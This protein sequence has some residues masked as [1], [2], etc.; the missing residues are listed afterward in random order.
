MYE[1]RKTKQ[2]RYFDE[3]IRLH[4]EE[5]YGENRMATILPIGLT[6]VWRWI[7]II[8]SQGGDVPCRVEKCE[9]M[10]KGEKTQIASDE[11]RCASEDAGRGSAAELREL[12]LANARLQMELRRERM[13]ADL[14]DEMINVGEAM[15]KVPIRKKVGAKQ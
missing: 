4:Y 8:V 1:L 6:T 11:R 14:L 5:G 13:R 12:K 2:L 7:S 3:V 9:D 10:K 15:F